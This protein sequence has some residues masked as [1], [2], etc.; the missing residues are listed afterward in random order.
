METIVLLPIHVPLWLGS[1]A[2]DRT[3]EIPDPVG[4]HL[5]AAVTEYA[6]VKA[7]CIRSYEARVQGIIDDF[8]TATADA[9]PLESLG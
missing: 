8:F 5:R 6:R 3:I 7:D 4:D 9:A 2:S 1:H